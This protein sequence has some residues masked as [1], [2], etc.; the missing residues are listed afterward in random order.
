MRLFLTA[1]LVLL[2]VSCNR[3]AVELDYTNAKGE[4]PRLG[5]LVFR[6]SNALAADSVLNE[7]DSSQYVRFVPEIPGRFRWEQPDQLV[8]S[9]SRPLPPATTF[10]AELTDDIIENTK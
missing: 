10:R 7:W 1:F 9:P 4:V 2:M 6:F 5:N 8:F 3:N